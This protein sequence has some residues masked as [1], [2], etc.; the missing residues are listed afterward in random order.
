LFGAFGPATAILSKLTDLRDHVG[1]IANVKHPLERP[2]SVAYLIGFTAGWEDLEGFPQME[3]CLLPLYEELARS[4]TLSFGKISGS[5]A[6]KLIFTLAW[7][8]NTI[9]IRYLSSVLPTLKNVLPPGYGANSLDVNFIL[10]QALAERH[11]AFGADPSGRNHSPEFLASFA[12]IRVSPD[13][14]SQLGQVFELDKGE[15]DAL[16]N[17]LDTVYR[18]VRESADFHVAVLAVDWRDLCRDLKALLGDFDKSYWAAELENDFIMAARRRPPSSSVNSIE[19]LT[20]QE[21][22]ELEQL[23]RQIA[24]LASSPLENQD[25]GQSPISQHESSSSSTLNQLEIDEHVKAGGERLSCPDLASRYKV[26]AEALRKRLERW[27]PTHQEDWLEVTNRRP[28]D[29]KYLYRV[30]AVLPIIR[31]LQQSR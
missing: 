5:S 8:A 3:Q 19:P 4:P 29:P 9:L 23:E 14:F 11:A 16:S 21:R 27:M 10:S 31:E 17:A 6:T 28:R 1:L 13:V 26:N 20:A 24:G 12:Q 25:K 30:S 15:M 7:T 2:R 22:S 18:N